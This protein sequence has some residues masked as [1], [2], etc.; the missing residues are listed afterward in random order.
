MRKT[1]LLA[2]LAVTALLVL[3]A[4]KAHAG[5][6]IAIGIPLPGVTFYAPAPPVYYGPPAYYGQS[7]YYP[8]YYGPSYGGVVY[9]GGGH[10]HGGYGHWGGH[11][12]Y[13]GGHGG[14]GGGGHGGHR[15]GH[16]HR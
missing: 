2:V 12:H 3:G 13:R 7:Y 11:N 16:R 1:S 5:V 8:R 6:D 4:P 14:H 9:F 15:G 10:G